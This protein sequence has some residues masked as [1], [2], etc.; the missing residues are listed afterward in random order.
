MHAPSL[1]RRTRRILAGT[2]LLVLGLVVAAWAALPEV[3]WRIKV[4]EAAIVSGDR[5]LLREIAT[6]VGKV[7][8]AAWASLGELELWQAPPQPFKPMLINKPRLKEA[9]SMYLG[10]MVELCMLPPSLA[11]Q[12]GGG[13]VLQD[14]LNRLLVKSL[15]AKAAALGGE[16][17]LKDPQTPPYIFLADPANQLDVEIAAQNLKPGRVS[18]RI[19]EIAMDGRV[20]KRSTASI[21]MDLWKTVPAAARPLNPGEEVGAKDVTFV[22]KNLAHL[23][24]E[25]WDGKPGSWRVKRP[26][27][28]GEPFYV[29]NMEPLPLVKRGDI[30]SLVYQGKHVKLQVPAEAMSDG[31][32]HDSITVRN[33][34]SKVQIH[35][36][37]LDAKTVQVF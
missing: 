31:G 22:R 34:Q 20:V 16:A 3:S 37:I 8:Q 27:G 13:V 24:D 18:L 23:R 10:D 2:A 36:R 17:E 30:V 35:A 7:D 21:Q 12:Q 11:L 5:V 26:I 25:I 9:L 28:A 32:Y 15:T 14:E 4:H 19:R 33:L 29:A 1:P 6:P